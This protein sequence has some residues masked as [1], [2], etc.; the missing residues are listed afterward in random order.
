MERVSVRRG[1]AASKDAGSLSPAI[2]QHRGSGRSLTVPPIVT[3]VLRSSGE[4]LPAAT[5]AHMEPRFSFDF[6]KVR[7]HADA[8]ASASARAVNALA[9][10]VGDRIAVRADK[11]APGTSA[12]K[13]LLAHEL[14]HVVQQARGG[15]ENEPEARA[16]AAAERIVHGQSV[17]LGMVGN[18]PFGLY[19]QVDDD[20][21]DPWKK[22][23]RKS[24]RSVFG[25]SV[26]DPFEIDPSSPLA[27]PVKT[28]QSNISMLQAQEHHAIN[29]HLKDRKEPETN[30]VE[31]PTLFENRKFKV[32][33]SMLDVPDGKPKSALAGNE[34]T[35]STKIEFGPSGNLDDG[36]PYLGAGATFPIRGRKRKRPPPEI[37]E[38]KKSNDWKARIRHL[39]QLLSGE[40]DDR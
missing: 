17:E 26:K 19:R 33:P 40:R 21:E 28:P 1:N 35:S 38:K 6:S 39:L 20:S 5:R 12:G 23:L 14:A 7:V 25:S 9:Y 32:Q 29:L 24:Q 27:G 18:A 10:T 11:Y 36:N 2:P 37:E 31:I 22:A 34:G 3:D 16:D 8:K 13:H 4:P 15:G 30:L